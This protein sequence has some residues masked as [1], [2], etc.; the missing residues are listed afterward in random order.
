MEESSKRDW[1]LSTAPSL[2]PSLRTTTV[3]HR[4]RRKVTGFSSKQMAEIQKHSF[5]TGMTQDSHRMSQAGLTAPM[6]ITRLFLLQQFPTKITHRLK[7]D[8][9]VVDFK[10]IKRYPDYPDNITF[11]GDYNLFMQILTPGCVDEQLGISH[12]GCT[13]AY[14]RQWQNMYLM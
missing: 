1:F 4:E 8:I 6:F 7:M 2:N 5:D 14:A 10:W 3:F 9:I 12:I 11:L 13:V